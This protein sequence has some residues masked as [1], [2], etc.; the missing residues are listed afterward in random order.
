MGLAAVKGL[1]EVMGRPAAMVSN[2]Q[3]LAASGTGRLRVPLLNARR[4][5]VYAGFYDHELQ[6]CEPER[7]GKLAMLENLPEDAEFLVTEMWPELAARGLKVRE[8]P[9]PLAAM[10]GRLALRA[11]GGDP[12]GIDANY[13]RRSDGDGRWEDDFLRR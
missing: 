10:V 4:G 5:E 7:V 9:E 13:V 1:A 11:G 6:A 8:Q 12:A 2:L 3:A